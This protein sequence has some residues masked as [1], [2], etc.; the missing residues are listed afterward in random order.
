MM[1]ATETIP[2]N[3]NT[4]KGNYGLALTPEELEQLNDYVKQHISYVSAALSIGID[5]N[6]LCRVLAFGTGSKE[7]IEKIK[8]A[9]K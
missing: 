9:L 8:A 3:G 6:V 5:R 7:T 2:Q 1:K 4:R